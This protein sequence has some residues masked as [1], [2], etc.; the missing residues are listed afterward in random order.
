MQLHVNIHISRCN[1]PVFVSIEVFEQISVQR[2]L[3]C[4]DPLQDF[5]CDRSAQDVL[6]AGEVCRQFEAA[7][8]RLFVQVHARKGRV[9]FLCA[10]HIVSICIPGHP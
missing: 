5:I 9:E 1:L 7:H 6:V 4:L 3:S 2:L 10:Y 8:F